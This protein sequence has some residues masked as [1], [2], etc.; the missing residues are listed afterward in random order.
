MKW[1]Y[2]PLCLH[3]GSKPFKDG[4]SLKD[5]ICR[6]DAPMQPRPVTG[7]GCI[8]A[9]CIMLE[10]STG[11]LLVRVAFMHHD[12]KGYSTLKYY[13]VLKGLSL[14]SRLIQW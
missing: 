11:E 3:V 5:D 1:A 7:Q 9:S 2:R 13:T 6:H 10:C 12:D 4:M 8:G 14:I